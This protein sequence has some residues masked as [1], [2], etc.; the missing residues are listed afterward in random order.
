M[1]QRI[2]PIILVLLSL[3]LAACGDASAEGP[4][5]VYSGRTEDLVGPLIEQFTEETGIEVDVRYG[6]STELAATIRLEGDSTPADV[7]L[8][9]DPASLGA[10]ALAAAFTPLPEDLVSLVPERFSDPARQWVG[11]SGRARTVVVNPDVLGDTPLPESIW[12]LTDPA[13]AGIGIA[14]TN[15]SFLAF[16]AAMILEQGEDRTLEWLEAIAANQPTD[17]PKNSPIVEAVDAGDPALGL[18]NHYYLLRL[19]AEQGSVTAVNHFLTAGD[20]GSLVMPS[21]AGILAQSER[22]DQAESF[23]RFMLSQTAQE[24][25]ATETF[26]YPLLSGIDPDPSLVPLDEL[27]TPDIDLSL[28]AEVLDRAT[29]LV[30][31]AGL[32]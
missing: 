8:A 13:Y 18:V 24:H 16:V 30:T 22:T 27:T 6:D 10:V 3:A 23:I 14:P 19:R 25:F 9:Q 11:I 20:A 17:F 1:K 29:E 15:G 5:V 32:I 31:L 12:D 26:E 2:L 28:L 4:L 21:G 7:F